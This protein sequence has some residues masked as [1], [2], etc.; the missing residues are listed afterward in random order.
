MPLEDD[1]VSSRKSPQG[2]SGTSM[3]VGGHAEVIAKQV[4]MSISVDDAKRVVMALVDK[5]ETGD[6]R[7]I[8]ILLKLIG[9]LV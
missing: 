5:A 7:A 3:S 1:F 6:I 4:L 8:E 9:F 2:G